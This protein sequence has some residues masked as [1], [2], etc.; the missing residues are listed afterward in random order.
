MYN[1]GFIMQKDIHIYQHG[2]IDLCV[3]IYREKNLKNRYE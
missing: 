2:F 3:I 1:M